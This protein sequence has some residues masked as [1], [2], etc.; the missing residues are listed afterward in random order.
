M[1]PRPQDI[2]I[3]VTFINEIGQKG[4]NSKVYL[5]KEQKIGRTIIIKEIERS[6]LNV[7]YFVEAIHL[8]ESKHPNIVEL[9]YAGESLCKEYIY[10]AMPYYK[11]GSLNKKFNTGLTI[12]EIIKYSLNFLSGLHSIHQKKLIHL[13]IKPDNILISDQNEALLSDFGLVHKINFKGLGKI[14]PNKGIFDP[15]IPPENLNNRHDKTSHYSD[16]YQS[17]ITLFSLV[18]Q[19]T[20]EEY[21]EEKLSQNKDIFDL[22]SKGNLYTS[23]KYAYHI[24]DSIKKIINKCLSINPQNRPI[25]IQYLL[26]QLSQIQDSPQLDWR[27]IRKNNVQVWENKQL[28]LYCTLTNNKNIVISERKKEIYKGEELQKLLDLFE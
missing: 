18:N 8:Y 23:N 25:S 28:N 21:I 16:I 7:N 5:A 20:I 4:R 17:G 9:S 3:P 24:P 6:N 10:F 1:T 22:I 26:N 27:Y 19:K 2:I 13:D 14:D 11:N 12:K 15:L